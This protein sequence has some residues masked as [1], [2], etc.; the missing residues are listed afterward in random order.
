MKEVLVVQ[1]FVGGRVGK[2]AEMTAHLRGT[3]YASKEGGLPG[4]TLGQSLHAE[5]GVEAADESV[6]GGLWGQVVRPGRAPAQAMKRIGLV[7]GEGIAGT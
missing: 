5:G 7:P 1:H 3:V 4:T 6:G 2:R